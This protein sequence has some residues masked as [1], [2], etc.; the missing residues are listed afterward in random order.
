MQ[1]TNVLCDCF[2]QLNIIQSKTLG[3]SFYIYLILKLYPVPDNIY[4][5][6][7]EAILINL[8]HDKFFIIIISTTKLIKVLIN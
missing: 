6:V 5:I 8:H 1:I 4:T 2:I 7:I 3:D